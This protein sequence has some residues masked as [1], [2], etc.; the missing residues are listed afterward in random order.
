MCKAVITEYV[1]NMQDVFE[2]KQSG[3]PSIF[4]IPTI[5]YEF[6]KSPELLKQYYKIREECYREDLGLEKFSG[7]E[8]ESDRIG[9]IAVA[10]AGEKVIG[11]A[12]LII[13]TPNSGIAL[14]LEA[15]HFMVRDLM[16]ELNG[17]KV[18]FC[19]ITRFAIIPSFRI[20]GEVFSKLTEMILTKAKN[21]GCHYQ[22]SVAPLAQARTYRM[23]SKKLGFSP[24]IRTD[25]EVPYKPIYAHLNDKKICLSITCLLPA[26]LAI[27][28]INKKELAEVV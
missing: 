15:D 22:L 23:I 25:I 18:S 16:P 14:P 24:V 1:N 9:Y 19:E 11:G 4:S 27:E 2:N 17:D 3:L 8:D 6:T 5:S 13:A 7:A 12:K 26:K 10:R 21:D 20:G 28:T